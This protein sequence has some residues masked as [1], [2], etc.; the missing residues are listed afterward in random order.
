MR[1]ESKQTGS[2]TL[3]TQSFV[4]LL[5]IDED[6]VLS[7]ELLTLAFDHSR[8]FLRPSTAGSPKNF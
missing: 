3:Q 1:S 6:T 4:G 2:K 8:Q 7:L 5:V